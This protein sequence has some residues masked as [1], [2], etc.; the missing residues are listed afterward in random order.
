MGLLFFF[1]QSMNSP[2][3]RSRRAK[4][5]PLRQAARQYV[6]EHFDAERMCVPH[7]RRLLEPEQE[8]PAHEVAVRP[9]SFAD[10]IGHP[11]ERKETV[12]SAKTCYAVDLRRSEKRAVD[13]RAAPRHCGDC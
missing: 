3:G 1:L 4:F 9:T 2:K 7:M 6:I 12:L 13:R 10:R 11:A 5:V 8:T